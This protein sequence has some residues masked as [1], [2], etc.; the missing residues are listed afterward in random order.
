MAPPPQRR[1]LKPEEWGEI[2]G[3]RKCG[4]SFATIAMN[5]ELKCDTVRKVWNYY[6]ETGHVVPPPRTGWPPIISERDCRHLRRHVKAI[7][8]YR[9]EALADITLT[10]NFNVSEDTLCNELKKLNLNHHIT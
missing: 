2:I 10:L 7:R 6:K 5:L 1:Q 9:R 3:M 4:V 8:E